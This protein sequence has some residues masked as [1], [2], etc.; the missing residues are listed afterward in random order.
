MKKL[1]FFLLVFSCALPYVRPQLNTLGL[2]NIPQEKVYL[3]T[4]TNFV[5]TGEYL[6]YQLYN[7]LPKSE[8]L[9]S[10][11]KIGYVDLINEGGIPI[12][13][14]KLILID[15]V[16]SSEFF[17]P[18]DVPS[19]NYK[20][21]GYTNWIKNFPNSLFTK[22]ITILNPYLGDQKVFLSDST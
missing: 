17:V 12:F 15:G 14:H 19:G 20:L 8:E 16:A 13:Q 1:S 22:D 4:N 3:H 9:S 21:V 6:Y 11:S 7:L 5:F 10:I 2:E 18:A